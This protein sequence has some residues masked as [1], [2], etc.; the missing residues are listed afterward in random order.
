MCRVPHFT[1]YR[2]I[3]QDPNVPQDVRDAA[4]QAI[5]Q[6]PM[7]NNVNKAASDVDMPVT[8][9]KVFTCSIYTMNNKDFEEHIRQE[10]GLVGPIPNPDAVMKL[11]GIL[12]KETN[13]DIAA[14]PDGSGNVFNDP[15]VDQTYD[16]FQTVYNFFKAVYGRNSIDDN[17]LE[18]RG[19]VHLSRGYDNAFWDPDHKAMFFGDGGRFDGRGW[20]MATANDRDATYLTNWHAPYALEIMGHELTH[21]VVAHTASLG[22]WQYQ[23]FKVAAYVEASTLDEHIA[24][25]FGIMIKQYSLNCVDASSADC[26]WNMAPEWYSEVAKTAM[27]WTKGYIRTFQKVEEAELKQQADQGPK[28]MHDLIPF[29]DP[30]TREGGDPHANVGIPNRAFYTAALAFAKDISSQNGSTTSLPKSTWQSVGKIWYSALTDETFKK[31]ENQTFKAWN[32]LT[33]QWAGKLFGDDGKRI[34]IDAWKEV[35]L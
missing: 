21:G 10:E 20:L 24:D 14:S 17:G 22:T 3:S 32:A 28:H 12:R 19:T 13:V 18:L 5:K 11:P 2:Q 27:G 4:S 23:H 34:M 16:S 15:I 31:P 6:G 7:Q 35:G 25:C 33:V 29:V 30:D 26:P 1:V 9:T 8:G